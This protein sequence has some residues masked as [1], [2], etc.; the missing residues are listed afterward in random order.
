MD[1]AASEPNEIIEYVWMLGVPLPAQRRMSTVAQEACDGRA[2]GSL[3][4]STRHL[5]MVV[6]GSDAEIKAMTAFF[7]IKICAYMS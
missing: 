2:T 1:N 5:K 4:A 6:P 7:S 3:N